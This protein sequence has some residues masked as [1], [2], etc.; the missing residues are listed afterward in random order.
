MVDCL[1]TRLAN[2][3]V[4]GRD[5]EKDKER[6]CRCRCCCSLTRSGCNAVA[7]TVTTLQGPHSLV[8]LSPM[9]LQLTGVID[10]IG[11]ILKDHVHL[12]Q[13]SNP[14]SWPAWP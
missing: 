1:R 4:R 2:F 13:T 7:V 14:G 3:V 6:E 12:D 11:P 8:P 5:T 9:L 10:I